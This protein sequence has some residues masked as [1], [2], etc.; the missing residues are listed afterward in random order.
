MQ[1][2]N[3]TSA[4]ESICGWRA[5]Q[6]EG[7]LTSAECDIPTVPSTCNALNSWYRASIHEL[8]VDFTNGTL[9]YMVW[10]QA[11]SPP[12]PVNSPQSFIEAVQTTAASCATTV[13]ANPSTEVEEL[14][15]CLDA[16]AG[17]GGPDVLNSNGVVCVQ[18]N[19]EIA[20]IGDALVTVIVTLSDKTATCVIR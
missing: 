1:G 14:A 12:D 4:S 16:A 8:R 15:G 20:S 2:Q 19:L 11:S 18:E 17:N 6:N 9:S 13:S 3:A 5:G 10:W 7:T